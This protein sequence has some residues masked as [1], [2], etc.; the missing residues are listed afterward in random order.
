[1]GGF[2]FFFSK[3]FIKIKKKII[4]IKYIFKNKKKHKK[5]SKILPLDSGVLFIKKL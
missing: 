5:K 4:S 1:M 2:P 3:N